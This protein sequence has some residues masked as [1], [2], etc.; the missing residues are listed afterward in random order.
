MIG[1]S[2]SE[3]VL[4]EFVVLFG[5]GILCFSVTLLLREVIEIY[6]FIFMGLNSISP[7]GARLYCAVWQSP[8]TLKL[9]VAFV[10]PHFRAAEMA[11]PIS[12]LGL[13][14]SRY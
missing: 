4:V 5:F 3:Q 2:N 11:Y 8:L 14:A 6:H 13:D 10:R 1:L 9:V 7:C 12:V